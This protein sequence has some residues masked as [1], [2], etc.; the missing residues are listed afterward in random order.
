[1][2]TSSPSSRWRPLPSSSL[3][4]VFVEDADIED[5][6]PLSG[7]AV[8]RWLNRLSIP[9]DW[10]LVEL[11]DGADPA[12]ARLVVCGPRGN[13]EWEAA[14]TISVFGYT[15]WPVFYDLFHNADHMLRELNA[16]GIAVQV[17]PVPPIQRAAALRCNGTATIGDRSV[18]VQQSNYVAGSELPNASRLIVHSMFVDSEC[19][20]RL[21]EDA[22]RLSDAV[23]QGY[24]AALL[25]DSRTG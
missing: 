19:R 8:P 25:S 12:L 20:A 7:P 17:L 2:S 23:Y 24:V 3:I 1:M 4:D 9:A 11:P 18:W 14:D 13:G 5:V 16:T 6:I 10:Q 21:A 22:T 15:G